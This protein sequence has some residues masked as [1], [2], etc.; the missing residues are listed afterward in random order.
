MNK[1]IFFLISLLFLMSCNEETKTEEVYTYSSPD[2]S[3]QDKPEP[4]KKCFE[5]VFTKD[6]LNIVKKNTALE[7]QI[8]QADV[9]S[10]K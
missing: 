3:Q 9:E 2:S 7:E 8:T 5:S 4:K 6:C 1:M 10:L